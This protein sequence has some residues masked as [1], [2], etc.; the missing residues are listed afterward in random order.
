MA[1]FLP[2]DSE[3]NPIPALRLKSSGAH[4]ISVSGSSARNSTAFD[5]ATRVI[6]LYATGAVYLNFGDVSVT[7]AATDHYFPAGVY[8]DVAIG[9][10]K[11]GHNT[12]VA[13]LRVTDDCT[14]YISEKE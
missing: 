1:T 11:S 5:G 4:S 10:G 13:A 9:G 14:L 7:A 3:N 12:H 6:S 8:Y 2:T